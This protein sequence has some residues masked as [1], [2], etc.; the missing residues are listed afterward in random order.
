MAIIQYSTVSLSYENESISLS[1][2]MC[3]IGGTLMVGVQ[4]DCTV[5]GIKISS[6]KEDLLRLEIDQIMKG[7]NPPVFT[8]SYAITFVPVYRSPVVIG[9]TFNQAANSLDIENTSS[10]LLTNNESFSTDSAAVNPTVN[11]INSINEGSN[12]LAIS[13]VSS[14]PIVKN[15]SQD[16]HSVDTIQTSSVPVTK[17]NL[18]NAHSSD[19]RSH[20]TPEPS[21]SENNKEK[22]Q[23]EQYSPTCVSKRLP[24]LMK[25]SLPSSDVLNKLECGNVESSNKPFGGEGHNHGN[26]IFER[27]KAIKT[28][29]KVIE[30]K[31]HH[32]EDSSTLYETNKGEVYIRRDGSIQGPLKASQ[33]LAWSRQNINK[34]HHLERTQLRQEIVRKQDEIEMNMKLVNELVK[35]KQF[36]EEQYQEKIEKLKENE[37]KLNAEIS[38]LRNQ[39]AQAQNGNHDIQ[40]NRSKVCTIF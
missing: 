37:D 26:E 16:C 20:S 14:V 39:E 2:L 18:I 38:L 40:R 36:V 29:L 11:I 6:K 28:D 12:S 35:Q 19:V 22:V 15:N 33:I 23:S 8:G 34:N 24:P 5:C 10:V 4:D 25:P 30:V 17:A 1:V 9:G 13:N 3:C 32:I 21:S 27:V 31:V 7:F